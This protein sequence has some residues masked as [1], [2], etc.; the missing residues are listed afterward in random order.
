MDL[1]ETKRKTLRRLQRHQR[2]SL[3][4]PA[5]N[6]ITSTYNSSSEGEQQQDSIDPLQTTIAGVV[7]HS[8]KQHSRDDHSPSGIVNIKSTFK[9]QSSRLP[10]HH[11]QRSDNN[12][13]SEW[14]SNAMSGRKLKDNTEVWD[15]LIK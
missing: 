15:A 9:H 5:H 3:L 2:N 7:H 13:N 4:H 11:H 6:N 1:A 8:S 10:K 14:W 12:N